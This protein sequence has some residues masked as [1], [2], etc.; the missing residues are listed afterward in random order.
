MEGISLYKSGPRD[1]AAA[2]HTITRSR[3]ARHPS[4]GKRR[5]PPPAA[6]LHAPTTT[7]HVQPTAR[8]H[9]PATQGD[10]HTPAAIPHIICTHTDLRAGGCLRQAPPGASQPG[11]HTAPPLPPGRFPCLGRSTGVATL[12]TCTTAAAAPTAGCLPGSGGGGGVRW[13]QLP[14]AP[15]PHGCTP[16]PCPPPLP[17]LHVCTPPPA[18]THWQ[19]WLVR[20]CPLLRPAHHASFPAKPGD[21]SPAAA[22]LLSNPAHLLGDLLHTPS[23]PHHHCHPAPASSPPA[24]PAGHTNTSPPRPWAHTPS[25]PSL[26]DNYCI[27]ALLPGHS[28]TA[29]GTAPA[30][31]LCCRLG[32]QRGGWYS[33]MRAWQPPPGSSRG[34][35]RGALRGARQGVLTHTGQKPTR[36]LP[37]C[38]CLYTWQDS[39]A[40]AVASWCG[41]KTARVWQRLDFTQ[42]PERVLARH[43]VSLAAAPGMS[44]LVLHN[45]PQPHRP[46]Q[47]PTAWPLAPLLTP[48][49]PSQAPP[50]GSPHPTACTCCCLRPAKTLPPFLQLVGA[51]HSQQQ[52]AGRHLPPLPV[53]C[54]LHP[55]ATRPS[56]PSHIHLPPGCCHSP[57]HVATHCIQPPAAPRAGP[58]PECRQ[59]PAA[60]HHTAPARPLPSW[61]TCAPLP[62]RPMCVCV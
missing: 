44:R 57:L 40:M 25:R 46:E 27:A 5:R 11:A 43:L 50:G 30:K 12:A 59:H 22:L 60:A 54:L 13:R 26:A 62:P 41:G 49:L 18:A 19:F 21:T 47:Q 39:V 16:A 48:S 24:A 53:F 29:C 9:T 45:T 8:R 33:G 37:C 17:P 56:P 61:A 6:A 10:A 3:T 14:L 4:R 35:T 51:G 15:L 23:I 55:P 42:S 52:R 36:W 34:S 28:P 2:Q 32:S 38:V 7:G 20:S 1:T 58:L 31:A